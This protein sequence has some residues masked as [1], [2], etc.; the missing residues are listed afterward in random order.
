MSLLTLTG[1]TIRIAGRSLLDNADL[2]ID[3]GRRVGLVGRNGAGKSTLLKAIAGDLAVD[4]GEIRLAA[5]ARLGRVKQEAPS[6]PA[7]LLETVLAADTE[8]L[9]LLA[10][11]DTADPHRLAEIHDRLIAIEADAAPSRAAAILAGLGFDGAAQARPVESF[12]GGWRMRVA[13]AAA[14]FAQPDLLLLDEP[15]NHLDL[16]ATLWLENWLAKFPGAAIVVSHDRGLLDRCVD[17]IAHLDRG[18]I[19]VT[20]GGYDEFVRIRTERA[21]QLAS[22]AEK[23]A[24]QR[25]HM[26]SFVDRFRA[27]ASKARQAQ[28]R[29]KALQKLPSLESVVEDAPTRFAFP[30]PVQIAPPILSLDRVSVGYDGT[31]VLRDL[32]LRVDMDDRIALLGANGNGKSTLAKLLAGRLEALSGELRR[33]PKLRVGY[34]A[35]HQEAELSHGETPILHMRRA[36]PRATPSQVR[37]QLARFGLDA[38]RADTRIENLSGGEKARLLLALA[39]RE[40]PHLLIL[41]EPTNH[42]D[43][44]AREALVRA[45]ADFSGAVLLITHDPHLVELV[46][47]RLWL[48]GDGTVT[49]FEGDLEDYRALLVERARPAAKSENGMSRKEERRDRAE[50]RA[51]MAPLRKRAKDA[52]A[53]LAKL[54]AERLRIEADLANPA[55]YV[56][57]DAAKVTTART[58]LAAINRETEAA[59]LDWLEA[60]EALEAAGV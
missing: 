22:M 6:G 49:P 21:M 15:T 53:K 38:D 9:T 17:S 4:G 37:A 40:A 28:S 48:V 14:L 34:F 27:K 24:K 57:G 60:A 13:L 55:L 58:R 31:P 51:A 56:N 35:Q 41:D 19:A 43:I 10:A 59:E 46:A 32:L 42:L 23:I 54:A 50:A 26:Q 11:L 2:T 45:L 7:S 33:G 30:E 8:R 18:K 39:T 47:D 29:L 25:A 12:S 16:E 20:P 3:P 5:R 36:L 44:D 1:I 52:E